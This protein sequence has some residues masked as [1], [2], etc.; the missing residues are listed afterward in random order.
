MKEGPK[1]SFYKNGAVRMKEGIRIVG[2]EEA[3]SD[4]RVGVWLCGM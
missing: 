2:M 3:R 1:E 4:G